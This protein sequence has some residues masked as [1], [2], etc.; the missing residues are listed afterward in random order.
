MTKKTALVLCG[1]G[2]T[3]A[4]YEIGALAAL[5]DFFSDGFQVSEF[6]VFVGTSAGAFV[7]SL[8]AAGVAPAKLAASIMAGREELIPNSQKDVY[9]ADAREVLGIVRD[10]GAIVGT[11]LARALRSRELRL[12]EVMKDLEDALPAGI[13]SLGHYERWL[14]GAFSRHGVPL[15]FTEIPRELHVTAIDLDSGRRAVFSALAEEPALRDAPI[16]RAICASSAIPGFFEPVEIGGRDYID[17][18]VGEAGHLD[19]ALSRGAELVVVVNPMVPIR[20]EVGATELPSAI[21]GVR[22][23]RDKGFLTVADQARRFSARTKLHSA[24]DRYRLMYPQST[25]VL[26][27]PQEDDGDMLLANPMNFAVRRR[28]L[29]YGYDSAARLLV[30]RAAQ[31]APV[32]A[33]HDIGTDPARLSERTWL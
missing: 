20:N 31:L 27:E 22:R 7:S 17:G 6:D 26:L 18:A 28:L 9:R 4:V 11:S 16:P 1:G 13:F 10:L 19:L 29:R 2:I 24:I 33:R 21:L 32:F 14:T 8:M 23:L 15:R 25:I 12:A 3:G 5:N 30:E